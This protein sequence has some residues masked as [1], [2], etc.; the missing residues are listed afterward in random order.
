MTAG[1]N[2]DF[3]SERFSPRSPLIAGKQWREIKKILLALAY[4]SPS[5]I[6][7]L[8]FVF[9]PLIRSFILSLQLT[10]PIGR[11]VA[12]VGLMQY[13]R[14]FDNPQF[15]NSLQRTLLFVIYTVPTTLV[16]ALILAVLGNL[17]LRHIS[18]FRMV[19]SLTLAVSAAT[20]SLIFLYLYHP[21]LGMLNYLLSL[22]GLPAVG[23]L[24][25]VRTALPAVAFVTVWLQ[26]GLN[27]VILLAGMQGIPE[28][29]YESAMIDG[30]SGTAKFRHIT[31][32]L[33]SPTLFFLLVVDLL[34]AFQTFTQFHVLTKGGPINSTNVL[35]FSIYREFYFNG[36]Y[37]Y[38]AAQSMV[39]FLIMLI[40]TIIQFGV[41]EKR[42]VYE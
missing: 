34:A 29:L 12:F 38:A 16:F 30:A 3:V 14:M 6:I 20:A 39:L 40:V 33:L 22:V 23:W 19:F 32:P 28:E 15:L 31:L 8:A 26:L 27:T 17:R 9:I 7:F 18:V 13:Q 10:D 2:Q 24:T 5:L 11:P 25:E 41:I 37:S 36:Q 35:V 1:Q 21:A 4:L 42:V